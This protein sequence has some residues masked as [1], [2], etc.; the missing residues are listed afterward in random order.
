MHDDTNH[1]C[2]GLEGI[3]CGERFDMYFAQA[4]F[5]KK[6][7]P[8]RPLEFVKIVSGDG[9][10]DQ[11]L[12]YKLGFVKAQFIADQFHLIDSGLKKLFGLGAYT[13]LKDHLIKLVHALSKREF[14]QTLELALRLLQSQAKRNGEWEETLLM[15]A[16]R[17]NTYSNY[18]LALL[19]GNRGKHGSVACEANHSSV[20]SYLNNGIRSSNN[21]TEQP[22]LLI[23]DLLR[24]QQHHVVL[25]NKRLGGMMQNMAVEQAKLA[26]EPQSAAIKDLIMASMTLNEPTYVRYKRNVG[27][28]HDYHLTSSKLDDG[29]TELAVQS[30]RHPDAPPRIFTHF[31]DRCKCRDRLSE[32]DMCVHEILAKGGFT[33]YFFEPR[34]KQREMVFGSIDGWTAPPLTTIDNLIGYGAEIITECTGDSIQ[35]HSDDTNMSVNVD[36]FTGDN[37]DVIPVG[38]LP[39]SSNRI[40]PF[41]KKH[42]ENVLNVVVGGYNRTSESKKYQISMLV[43]KMQELMT[44]DS[45]ENN[46]VS[47][48]DG[49]TLSLPTKTAISTQPKSRPKPR[50]ECSAIAASKKLKSSLQNMGMKQVVVGQEYDIVANGKM[51]SR[52]CQFCKGGHNY[53]NCDRRQMYK[54]TAMEYMLSSSNNNITIGLKDRIKNSMPAVT[55]EHAESKM[56]TSLSV[57]AV[58]MKNVNF[59]IHEAV[60]KPGSPKRQIESMDFCITFLSDNG[61]HW[62]GHSRVWVTGDVMVILV[63]HTNVKIKFVFDETIHQN[64]AWTKEDG[65]LSQCT[66]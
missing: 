9:F 18:K 24:R 15:F 26:L 32:L 57:I 29:S 44:V 2:I 41:S 47:R 55:R 39:D 8:G 20:L 3:V 31:N 51:R 46:T 42:V 53:T 38:Q 6:H 25:T 27:R 45:V 58:K 22:I 35:T 13:L 4:N 65:T 34:H 23:R 48:K 50:H 10:F 54:L 43:L 40:Q 11:D 36:K 17:N 33:P 52:R 7:S 28:L 21:Y 14:D 59:I 12:T 19:P 63:S 60:V 56:M 62:V 5:L 30:N 37:S 1:I 49:V 66:V 64:H 61:E 16:G